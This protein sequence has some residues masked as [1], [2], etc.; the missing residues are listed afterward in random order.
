LTLEL[1]EGKSVNGVKLL[2]SEKKTGFEVSVG[3]L[4]LSVPFILDHEVVAVDLS[5]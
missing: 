1:P 2:M 5:T 3:K 4:R